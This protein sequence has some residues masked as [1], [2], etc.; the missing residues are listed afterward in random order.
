M[1]QQREDDAERPPAE[2]PPA[3]VAELLEHLVVELSDLSEGGLDVTRG[4]IGA[5]VDLLARAHH[6][7]HGTLRSSFGLTMTMQSV[8]H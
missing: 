3:Q 4:N 2:C 7:R 6:R 5:E 8:Q 1:Q